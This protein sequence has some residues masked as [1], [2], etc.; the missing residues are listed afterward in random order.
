ML[1]NTLCAFNV[2][3]ENC[4]N[5]YLAIQRIARSARIIGK[6]YKNYRISESMLILWAVTG[7]CPYTQSQLESMKLIYDGE[8]LSDILEWVIDEAVVDE[9]TRLYKKSVK[10]RHLLECNRHDFTAA[11]KDR[12]NILLRMAWLSSH[13]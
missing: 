1:V 12:V 10:H 13:T 2:L 3:A 8:G 11:R 4:G 6:K 7:T 9:V 5:R